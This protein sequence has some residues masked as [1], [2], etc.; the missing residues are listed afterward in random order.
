MNSSEPAVVL[1]AVKAVIGRF[2]FI[3]ETP[4]IETELTGR[5]CSVARWAPGPEM[6]EMGRGAE[7]RGRYCE[8]SGY[9]IGML[10]YSDLNA[11]CLCGVL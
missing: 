8:C 11:T 7:L 6:C 1:C 9:E 3:D 10:R 2:F 5:F 4:W